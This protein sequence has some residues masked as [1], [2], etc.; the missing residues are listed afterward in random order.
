M[1]PARPTPAV[2]VV[3]LRDDEIL[4]VQRGRGPS[5]GKWAVPGGKVEWG[6]PL[7]TAA[8]REVR[9]ETGLTV[10][11]GKV[12]WVGEVIDDE[13]HYV[14]IDF[15]G[16]VTGGDLAAADDAMAAAW[17]DVNQARRWDLTDTMYDLLDLLDE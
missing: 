12:I 7:R 14:L 17:V 8:R 11:I 5:T 9:E 16:E 6:E 13:H 3:V 4:L 10:R 2:G 1:M 15:L